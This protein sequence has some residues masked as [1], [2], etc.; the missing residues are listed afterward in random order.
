MGREENE[1]KDQK[2]VI[3]WLRF[4]EAQLEINLQIYQKGL[5]KISLKYFKSATFCDIN[6][7]ITN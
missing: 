7:N 4:L 5:I 6:A 1:N 2:G 3:K